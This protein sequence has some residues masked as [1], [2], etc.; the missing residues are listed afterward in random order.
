MTVSNTTIGILAAL[1]SAAS[2]S[3]GA[4]LF[5]DLGASLSSF[6]M[7]LVKGAVSVL[8]LGVLALV[9]GG[10]GEV[11]R[12]AYLYLILSGILGIALSDTLF[13]SALK[14]VSPQVITLLFTFGQVVT[15]LLAVLLL[16][17]TLSL[18]G[19]AGIALIIT[20]I[21]IGMLTGFSGKGN[22]SLRG[23]V[24]GLC[25]ILLMSFS[26][27][28]TKKGLTGVSTLYA[29]FI[30]M[31]AGTTGM[32]L[33]GAATGR[34]GAWVTPFRDARLLL[35]FTLSVAV[36]TFGGF[37]LAIVAFKYT[38]VAVANSLISTEPIFVLPVAALLLKEKVTYQAVSGAVV[39][40][41]G[42]IVLCTSVSMG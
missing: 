22:S 34:L 24:L 15:V 33:V 14:E 2:W 26:V 10:Y 8:L 21:T 28:L 12:E 25:S 29:T 39:A 31:L 1:G 6:A 40:T 30:R 4:V 42:V 13:F 7:T 11:G 41:V 9:T 38:S 3:L 5:K 27:I 20:G 18:Q 32:L 37:W 19:W 23:I 16:G 35:K 17:E 36:I